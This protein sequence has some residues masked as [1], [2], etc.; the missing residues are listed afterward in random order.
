MKN[1]NDLN[2]K[3]LEALQSG[4]LTDWWAESFRELMNERIA[5]FTRML[6]KENDEQTRGAIKM[7]QEILDLPDT[8]S[9]LLKNMK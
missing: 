1:L 3:E 5:F 4:M 8:I 2:Y 7:L 9:E 6:I